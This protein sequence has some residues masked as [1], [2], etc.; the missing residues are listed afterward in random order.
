MPAPADEEFTLH[1]EGQP[2]LVKIAAVKVET[3]S[4][5]GHRYDNGSVI[6]DDHEDDD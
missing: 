2:S 1:L 3:S 6:I 4:V 5:F